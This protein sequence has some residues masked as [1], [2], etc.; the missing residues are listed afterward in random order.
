MG[1]PARPAVTSSSA[2]RAPGLV[3]P[4]ADRP[5]PMTIYDNIAFVVK[6][7]EQLS[8]SE[9]TSRWNGR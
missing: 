4:E 3:F 7:F 5:F 8:R 9:M 6:M 1:E 2:A